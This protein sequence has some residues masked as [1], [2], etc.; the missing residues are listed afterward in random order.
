[1]PQYVYRP[2]EERRTRAVD[3]FGYAAQMVAVGRRGRGR[4]QQYTATVPAAPAAVGTGV[5]PVAVPPPASVQAGV[6]FGMPGGPRTVI[7]RG[8]PMRGQFVTP[9]QTY[10]EGNRPYLYD[11]SGQLQWQR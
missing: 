1:M 9:Y 6:A 3:P 10:Y 2:R 4:A 7:A 11:Q 5:I 8:G